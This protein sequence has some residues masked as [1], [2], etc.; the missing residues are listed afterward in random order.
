[1][2]EE[3]GWTSVRLSEAR[4]SGKRS[5][6]AV[7]QALGWPRTRIEFLETGRVRPEVDDLVVFA[8]LYE[9]SSIDASSSWLWGRR[10]RILQTPML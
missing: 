5:R 2:P 3:S 7:A 10:P 1:M 4:R 9:L 8:H 6:N